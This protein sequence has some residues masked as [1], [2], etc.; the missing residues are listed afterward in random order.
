ML[1]NY[2]NSAAK[3]VLVQTRACHPK[4]TAL[5]VG[6]SYKSSPCSNGGRAP[7]GPV[8]WSARKLAKTVP[9]SAANFPIAAEPAC[10]RKLNR[11]LLLGCIKIVFT[12]G[13]VK[14]FQISYVVKYF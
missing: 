6:T 9:G 7:A 1:K 2:C 3:S 5:I 4:F 10:R 14:E 11:E 8:G 13:N 12:C